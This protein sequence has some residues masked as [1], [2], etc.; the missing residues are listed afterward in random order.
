M[1]NILTLRQLI[2]EEL[3]R[4]ETV[5]IA[6]QYSAIEQSLSALGIEEKEE[7][8]R[9]IQAAAAAAGGGGL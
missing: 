6:A 9:A 4:E 8:M 5:D 1:I 3:L 2:R 7:I